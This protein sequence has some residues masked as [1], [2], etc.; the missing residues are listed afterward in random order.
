[1]FGR[2]SLVGGGDGILGDDLHQVANRRFFFHRRLNEIF[3]V[4]RVGPA[5]VGRGIGQELSFNF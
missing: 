3:A 1:M 2:L 4:V 5:R